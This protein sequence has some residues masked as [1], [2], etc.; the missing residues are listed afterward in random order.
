MNFDADNQRFQGS[1]AQMSFEVGG[2]P[3]QW[4]GHQNLQWRCAVM[5]VYGLECIGY[6]NNT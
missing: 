5:A 6:Y 2:Y 3:P 1:S 4:R